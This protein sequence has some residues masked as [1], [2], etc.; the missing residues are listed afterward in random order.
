MNL[1]AGKKITCDVLV[2]GGGIAG[3]A[4]AYHLAGK[5]H[6]VAVVEK[7]ARRRGTEAVAR[8]YLEFL[9]TDQGQEIIAKNFYRPRNPAVAARFKQQFPELK[10][11]T[12][13][14]IFGGWTKAQATHFAEG[15]VFDQVFKP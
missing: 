4:A 11:V 15:G 12:V 5:G 6:S 1:I 2:A 9:Y 3:V 7:V 8:A 14:A 13:D 10:L